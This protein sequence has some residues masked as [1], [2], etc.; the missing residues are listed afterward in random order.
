[1]L[2]G[3]L[4]DFTRVSLAIDSAS[5]TPRVDER[6][7][8]VICLQHVV[9]GVVIIVGLVF[10]VRVAQQRLSCI[11]SNLKAISKRRWMPSTGAAAS[12]PRTQALLIEP[13]PAVGCGRDFHLIFGHFF[14]R[15]RVGLVRDEEQNGDMSCSE[16]PVDPVRREKC[17]RKKKPSELGRHLGIHA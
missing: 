3:A 5:C 9:I 17:K 2:R 11:I 1:M 6:G 7:L 14:S 16:Q 12:R 15:D 8:F 13:E 4:I 10:V